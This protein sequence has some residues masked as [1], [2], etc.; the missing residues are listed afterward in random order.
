MN[1]IKNKLSNER[2]ILQDKKEKTF[3]R[4]IYNRESKHALLLDLN[5][6][7]ISLTAMKVDT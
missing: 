3:R 7:R 1:E 2:N 4:F 5:A 6:C